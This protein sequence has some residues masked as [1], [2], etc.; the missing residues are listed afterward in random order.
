MRSD[1]AIAF[2]LLAV[3]SWSG[4]VTGAGGKKSRSKKKVRAVLMGL[5]VNCGQIIVALM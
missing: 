2:T 4:E 5:G 3:C 1:L